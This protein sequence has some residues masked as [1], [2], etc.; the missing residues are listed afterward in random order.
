FKLNVGNGT[1]DVWFDGGANADVDP[2][3]DQWNHFAFT[4][5]GTEC[6]VY[7]NGTVVSEGAFAG[8]DWTGC[9]VLSI[10]SG[11]PRFM[12]WGHLSDESFMDE[13]RIFNK[14][15]TQAEIQTIIDDEN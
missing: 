10:M 8:V 13:L 14:A 7:I 6:K 12:E 11:A 5:S 2:T 15:L 3:V 4:I 9:D 1:A